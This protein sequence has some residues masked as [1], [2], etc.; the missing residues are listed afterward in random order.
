M[1]LLGAAAYF[2]G[3]GDVSTANRLAEWAYYALAGGVLSMLIDLAL[4]ERKTDL[5]RQSAST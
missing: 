2:L 5:R 3:V 4:A 1:A